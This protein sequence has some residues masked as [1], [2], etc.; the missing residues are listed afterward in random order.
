[1]IVVRD[2]FIAKYGKGGE[3]AAH[4][5]NAV[6]QFPDFTLDRILTDVSGTFF[7]VITEVTLDSLSDWEKYRGKIFS[8]PGFGDWFAKMVPM[9]ESGSREF[10]NIE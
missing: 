2:V 3:L 1:M 10:L 6:E 4:F 7:T 9:V 5:K 8:E